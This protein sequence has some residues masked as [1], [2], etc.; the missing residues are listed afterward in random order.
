MLGLCWG[1][2]GPLL[3]LLPLSTSTTHKAF[4]PPL[5]LHTWNLVSPAPWQV[6]PHPTH[7]TPSQL[8]ATHKPLQP[9]HS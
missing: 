7:P 1:E 9:T 3:C 4:F 8:L 6:P 2:A 5:P